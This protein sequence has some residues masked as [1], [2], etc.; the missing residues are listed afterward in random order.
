MRLVLILSLLFGGV[1]GTLSCND[2]LINKDKESALTTTSQNA[3]NIITAFI[4]DENKV[5]LNNINDS[6]IVEDSWKNTETK[7][8]SLNLDYSNLDTKTRYLEINL[9]LGMELKMTPDSIVDDRNI[10]SV[11]KSEFG[12]NSFPVYNNTNYIANQGKLIYKISESVNILN[13][14]LLVS[15]DN[16]LWNTQS[17]Y[18][19]NKDEFAIIITIGDSNKNLS[20][21]LDRVNIIK[22]I[23]SPNWGSDYEFSTVLQNTDSFYQQWCFP[24]RNYS[25]FKE[26]IIE[27]EK[28]Y[29]ESIINGNTIKKYAE[30][31]DVNIGNGT[32]EI[33]ND[34]ILFKYKNYDHN[35]IVYSFQ[36]YADKEVFNPGEKIY[37]EAK[38]IRAVGYLNEDE[39]I[40]TKGPKRS[41][42]ILSNEYE[43]L[44]A[45]GFGMTTY[46]DKETI[47]II[48]KTKFYNKG[49]NSSNK[50]I[51]FNFPKETIGIKGLYIP[52]SYYSDGYNIEAVLW[53]SN[54][55]NE[56]T[57]NFH[58]SKK[59]NNEESIL[60]TVD[61]ILNKSDLNISD[62][63][64]L[65]IKSIQ[66]DIGVIRSRYNKP[67]N[68]IYGRSLIENN[69]VNHNYEMEYV[70]TDLDSVNLEKKVVK[71]NVL[72]SNDV[73]IST[74]MNA[75]IKDV[76][77]NDVEEIQAGEEF[78]IKGELAG[79]VYPYHNT[80][81]MVNPRIYLK[82]PKGFKINESVI[83]IIHKDKN[84]IQ[85][86][87]SFEILNKN[88]PREFNDGNLGYVIDIKNEN[89]LIGYFDN[90]LGNNGTLLFEI[91]IIIS[92]SVKTTRLNFN[93]FLFIGD[94]N[95]SS[96]TV[97]DIFDLNEN[98]STSDYITGFD[99]TPISIISNTNWLDV[100]NSVENGDGVKDKY[101][102]EITDSSKTLR[103]SLNINNNNEG[104]VKVANSEYYIPIPKKGLSYNLNI[105]PD[106]ID[107]NFDMELAS[108]PTSIEKHKVMYSYDDID[109]TRVSMVKL[110]NTE[111]ILHGD[112]YN[113]YVD[114]RYV[115]DSWNN[116]SASNSWSAYGIQTY[117]KNDSDSTYVHIFDP[118]TV[119]LKFK[120]K[121]IRNPENISVN[122]GE[123]AV[124]SVESDL[125]A[126]IATTKWQYRESNT[127][128]WV[129]LLE[130]D[131]V[132][133]LQNVRINMNGYEYRYIADNG[134]SIEESQPATLRVIDNS[135]PIIELLE[136]KE[137]NNYK[138]QINVTDDDNG[139]SHIILPDGTRIDGDTYIIDAIP[140]IKYIFKAYD[141]AGNESIAELTILTGLTPSLISSNIDIYI[142][143]ENMLSMSLDTNSVSFEDFSGVNDIELN[144]AINISINSSLP[145]QLNSY[146]LSEMENSDKSNRIEKDLLN[147]K[148][149]SDTD[150]KIFDDINEKLIL[151]ND[152]NAGNNKSHSID[153]KLKGGDAHKA[154][155]YKA[156]I[157]FEVEQK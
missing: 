2:I 143:S 33:L 116:S 1:A 38:E 144:N 129:D 124:F 75:K 72:L 114:M 141:L 41:A 74:S 153:L 117:T 123:N 28:P 5:Y 29:T 44:D 35:L 138:I 108:I 73:R 52:V 120:P 80:S 107:F 151:E 85:S 127:S 34:K 13:L 106:E 3:D 76:S 134:V 121:I 11:D 40:L 77:S 145:Y 94:E 51:T 131:K 61:N 31:K 102:Q 89:K 23:V 45:N 65:Y 18:S 130:D 70:L 19:C 10:L 90:Q 142:K 12:L 55:D 64:N 126:P 92:K 104:V 78:V 53:D 82:L 152:C 139:V 49:I 87:L 71:M 111:E 81:T 101:N 83:K 39:V 110:I 93:E 21:K 98:G 57:L 109:I 91:P 8:L 155:V 99:S 46:I 100:D 24:N 88:T 43:V 67:N 133:I 14:D 112:K 148:S 154:D 9:P 140:N 20:K 58:Q 84:N 15:I 50:S 36:I 86:N 47:N 135:S 26:I 147:I 103:Y 128:Q 125:G 37:V 95:I 32:Y 105:K 136:I 149:S 79:T 113:F 27:V 96:G 63:S 7:T 122:I 119:K 22:N 156:V 17:Q 62:T 132:L 25:L 60:L 146:L 69:S 150:Y 66:Y 56:L 157:K 48:G 16:K 59:I 97:R 4:D 137:G 118:L 115:D 30:V 42:E 6:T 68:W 54:V